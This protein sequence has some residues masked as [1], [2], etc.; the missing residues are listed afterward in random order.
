[1]AAVLGAAAGRDL[2]E[3]LR[4]VNIYAQLIIKRLGG[5]DSELNQYANFVRQGITRMDALID[6]LTRRA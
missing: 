6:D 3:P 5:E 4:G 1:L 2:R